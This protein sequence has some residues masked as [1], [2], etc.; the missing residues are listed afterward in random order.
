MLKQNKFIS[1]VAIGGTAL[2]IMMIMVIV[3]VEEIKTI[4]VSPENN[5]SRTMHIKYESL[6]MKDGSNA[7]GGYLRMRVLKYVY[8]MQIPELIS[9]FVWEDPYLIT[10][11]T[12]KDL[13]EFA[14][15][16]YTDSNFWKIMSFSFIEGQPY[17][18]ADFKA[19]LKKVVITE[20]FSKKFF[21]DTNSVGKTLNIDFKPCTVVGV[22]KNVSPVFRYA[23]GDIWAPYTIAEE[24]EDSRIYE[25]LL[26]ANSRDDFDQIKEEARGVE[27]KFN[28]VDKDFFLELRGPYTPTAAQLESNSS[29]E[30][31]ER[32][33]YLKMIFVFSILIIIPAINLLSISMSRIKKRTEEIGI[34]KAFGAKRHVIIVQ[35]LYENMITSFIGGVIG[36]MLSFVIVVWLK[37]WL[38]EM[39]PGNTIPIQTLISPW[40]FLI[41]FLVSFLFNLLTAGIPA[42]RASRVVIV[43]SLNKKED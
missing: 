28:A 30:P 16:K 13:K 10:S 23:Y 29:E 35:V 12:N 19:G 11:S 42:Y 3:V 39:E 24:Y 6:K 17:D 5:R 8:E 40:V 15:L 26:L 34:R 31:D 4:N 38:L 36:L 18:E 22:V 32:T 25:V 37:E 33:A 21:G 20:S 41:V 7:F 2:A 1:S 27:R 14:N 9:A 43:D